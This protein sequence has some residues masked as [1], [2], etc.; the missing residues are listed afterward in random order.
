[1]TRPMACWVYRSGETATLAAGG[2]IAELGQF[3]K[4]RV[5]GGVTG[6]AALAD[7]RREEVRSVGSG[8]L[9]PAPTVGYGQVFGRF[10]I[11]RVR[12]WERRVGR[13]PLP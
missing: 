6:S 11:M 9:L 8:A 1:M 2:S 4:W 12:A 5:K 13:S 10:L 3:V 7:V